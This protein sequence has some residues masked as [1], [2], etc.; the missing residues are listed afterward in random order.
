[1]KISREKAQE[2]RRALLRAAVRLIKEQGFDEV[3]VAEISRIA[4]LTQGA[5]YSHF[6][7]KIELAIEASVLAQ[8][9][10]V[11]LM[12]AQGQGRKKGDIS[13]YLN[14]YLSDTNRDDVANGC[15]MASNVSEVH[16]QP[17]AVQ[18]RFTRGFEGNVEVIE[19]ALRERLSPEEARRR[20]VAIVASMVGGLA[21]ARA[22]RKTSSTLSDEIL[23]ATRAEIG[24]IA[25]MP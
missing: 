14:F 9:D 10:G 24:R 1:M 21:M 13:P 8:E 25:E 5:F 20:A 18:H 3:S 19:E 6:G 4:G 2:N 17:E 22:I 23:T 16:R 12:E 11:T 15:P 7:S